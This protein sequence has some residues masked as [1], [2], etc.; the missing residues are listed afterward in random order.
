M[1]EDTNVQKKIGTERLRGP[2]GT[3]V[4][5]KTE[6]KEAPADSDIDKPLVTVSVQ[7]PFKKLLHWIDQIRRKQNTTFSIQLKLPLVVMITLFVVGISML[8][9]SK[10]FYDWGMTAGLRNVMAQPQPTPAIIVLPTATPAPVLIT[11][12]GTLKGIY[13]SDTETPTRYVLEDRDGM[14]TIII[15]TTRIS[16][17]QYIGQR[18]LV[19]GMYD[20]EGNTLKIRTAGDVEVIR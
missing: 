1:P 8:T 4:K 2:D 6:T 9:S 7:N 10:L 20:T 16:L 14:L 19:T 11:K 12:L 18:V 17:V 3:F 13:T 5:I 15:A